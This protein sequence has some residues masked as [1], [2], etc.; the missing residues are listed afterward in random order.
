VQ[1]PLR[2]TW[3]ALRVPH[4]APDVRQ[5]QEEAWKAAVTFVLP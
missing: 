2:P 4:H 3:D 1:V 5:V